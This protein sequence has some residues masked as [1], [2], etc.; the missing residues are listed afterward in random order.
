MYLAA[1]LCG[2]ERVIA[3][4]QLIADPAPL[5][6]AEHGMK[7]LVRRLFGWRTRYM[8][9]KQLQGH[10]V[11]GKVAVYQLENDPL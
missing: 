9:G 11:G 8:F 5:P 4:E 1:R 7:S 2:A 3:I 10:F 6:I